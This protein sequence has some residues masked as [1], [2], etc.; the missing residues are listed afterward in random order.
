M[1]AA[2]EG[3]TVFIG[4]GDYIVGVNFG[5]GETHEPAAGLAGARADDA[6]AGDVGEFFH[7][8]LREVVI[9]GGDGVAADLVEV[10]AGRAKSN[11][12]GDVGRAGFVRSGE[13]FHVAPS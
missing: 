5:E 8:D 13:G 1:V 6:D 9:V 10:I 3:E 11:G 4:K 2:A 12:I 7:R